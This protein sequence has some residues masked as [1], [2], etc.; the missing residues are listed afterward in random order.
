M[1][2]GIRK[3]KESEHKI[4]LAIVVA[5]VFP[6]FVALVF[7]VREN[8]DLKK[9]LKE[10]TAERERLREELSGG[11]CLKKKSSIIFKKQFIELNI[12]KIQIPL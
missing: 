4:Y 1:A 9:S 7:Y 8:N 5:V 3:R 6:V 10:V 11:N 2:D 12:I